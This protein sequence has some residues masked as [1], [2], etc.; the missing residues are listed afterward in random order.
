MS[1]GE[2]STSPA[3]LRGSRLSAASSGLRFWRGFRY[4]LS[5]APETTE[6]HLREI[7]RSEADE[8]GPRRDQGAYVRRL[9]D[10]GRLP[11]HDRGGGRTAL[12]GQGVGHLTGWLRRRL[13]GPG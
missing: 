11:D 12:G 4:A 13:E 9:W 10:R 7:G 3:R 8:T 6:R 5:C 2:C 1:S